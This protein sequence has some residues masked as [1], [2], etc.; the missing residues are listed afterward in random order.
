MNE[1]SYLDN[2][3]LKKKLTILAG[4]KRNVGI[5]TLTVS[6]FAPQRQILMDLLWGGAGTLDVNKSVLDTILFLLFV[7]PVCVDVGVERIS[8]VFTEPY[9]GVAKVVLLLCWFS[10]HCI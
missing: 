2:S 7:I 1:K 5:K 8:S 3:E 6:N 9:V 4:L 10:L